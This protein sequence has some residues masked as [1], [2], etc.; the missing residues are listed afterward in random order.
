MAIANASGQHDRPVEER[1]H[2]ADKHKR[3]EPAG[4]TTGAGGQ[5]HESVGTHFHRAL[6]VADAGDIGEYQGAS[7]MQGREHGR[8]RSDAGDD[9]FGFMPQQH[10]QIPWKPRVGTVHDQVRADRGG[11]FSASVGVTP[12]PG[13][14]VA[15]PA[16]ELFGAA[17]IHRRERADHAVAA[18]GH[19]KIDAGDEEHRRRDQRQA[20]AVAKACQRVGG[21]LV[22]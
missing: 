2:R 4:L 13:F 17:A 19:H 20:Q 16:V 21:L 9:D 5:Q 18:S 3:V 8:G 1:P 14:D 11:R 12:Q 7:V 6:G 10:L 22:R 15:E